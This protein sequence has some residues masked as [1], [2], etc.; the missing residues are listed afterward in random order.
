MRS[1]TIYDQEKWHTR[2]LPKGT[3]RRQAFVHIAMYI[4]WVVARRLHNPAFFA[5]LPDGDRYVSSIV[6]RKRTAMSMRQLLDGNLPS[7]V[8]S[9]EG[10]AF[11]DWYYSEDHDARY[12]DDWVAEFGEAA[13]TYAVPES[14]ESFDRIAP[15][16]DAQLR[17]W[18]QQPAEL[19]R[20]DSQERG[21][22]AEWPAVPV[23]SMSPVDDD[24]VRA[25]ERA[26]KAAGGEVVPGPVER[27]RE[28]SARGL[29]AD[30]VAGLAAQLRSG[31]D[32]QRRLAVA[33]LAA[34]P[35]TEQVAAVLRTAARSPD[36]VVAAI[37]ARALGER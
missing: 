8:L 22:G 21:N 18:R 16:I 12:L 19:R 9:E 13:N 11:T 24:P 25:A 14:W 1:P 27:L 23:S 5:A 32:R 34:A 10:R 36:P 30:D 26:I 20:A 35:Q 28:G 15:R 2:G 33:R 3:P 4:T 7:H 37:A 31:S 17:L 29:A 6:R